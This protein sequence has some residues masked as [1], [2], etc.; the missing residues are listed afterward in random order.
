MSFIS[1]YVSAKSLLLPFFIW[2]LMNMLFGYESSY[3]DMTYSS[4]LEL[5]GSRGRAAF[6]F[7]LALGT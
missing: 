5:R 2:S 4:G 7:G 3:L 1:V 6:M